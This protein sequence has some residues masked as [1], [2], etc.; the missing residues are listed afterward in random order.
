MPFPRVVLPFL[1]LPPCWGTRLRALPR[2]H[3]PKPE[4]LNRLKPFRHIYERTCAYFVL[5]R[6]ACQVF[7][8]T[9]RLRDDL[10]ASPPDHFVCVP[11]VLDALHARVLGVLRR[12]PPVRR[13][14]AGALLAA[15]AA[16]TAARRVVRGVALEWARTPRPVL[17]LL[18]AWLAVGLL[19]PFNW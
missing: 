4:T 14:L 9:R 12:A 7:S 18:K 17:A 1:F 6:G 19:A 3:P 5:S 8:N 16:Y 15:A 10:Q 13:A 11:L 2:S